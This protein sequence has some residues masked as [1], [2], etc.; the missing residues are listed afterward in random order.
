MA[1]KFFG[2]YLLEKGLIDKSQLLSALAKQREGNPR[3]GDLAT[4][5]GILSAAES[6][7]INDRQKNTDAKFGDIAVSM[8][9]LTA[10]QLQQLIDIQHGSRKFF[11]EVLIDLQYLSKK[12]VTQELQI[13]QLEQKQLGNVIKITVDNHRN[14]QSIN[15]CVDIINKLFTRIL[16]VPAQFSELASEQELIGNCETPNYVSSITIESIE[17][18]TLSLACQKSMMFD[19]ASRLIKI[20]KDDVDEELAWDAAGEFLNIITGYYAKDTIPPDCSY[21]VSPPVFS[22][23]LNSLNNRFDSVCGLKIDSEI[24]QF[25]VCISR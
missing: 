8:Q 2:Q 19:I 15:A 16:H 13:Y 12:Q 4:Q 18:I 21:R 5:I 9:L 11:G 22:Q 10:T 3:L 25:F 23:G 1:T 6:H 14:A 24:G 20:D 7:R 17:N